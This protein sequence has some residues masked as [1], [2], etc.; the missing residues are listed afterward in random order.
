MKDDLIR[1]VLIVYLALLVPIDWVVMRYSGFNVDGDAIS[2]MDLADLM[3]HGHWASVANGYWNPLY[4]AL[5]A[6]AQK[7]AHP[8]RWNELG[9]YLV[10]NYFIFAGAVAAMW[11]FVSSLDRLRAKMM[12]AGA[13]PLLGLATLR[14]LGIALLVVASQRE[15]GLDKVRSDTLLQALMMMAFAMLMESLA[16]ASLWW[17]PLMGVFFGLAYL[18]K[19]FAFVVALLTIALMVV[20]QAWLQ[21]RP[22]SRVVLAGTLA[23]VAFVAVAGP[24][25]ASLSR[26]K[27]RLDFGDSGSLNYAW[28]SGGTEKFH[29]QPNQ[30]QRY[31]GAEVHLI[32]PELQLLQHP[33]I[34]SY[35]G[36]PNGTF[37]DWFDASYFNERIKPHL[38][39]GI[40]FRRIRRNIV[41]VAR[42]LLNHPEAWVL[43]AVLLVFGA[44]MRFGNW[45]RNGFWLPMVLLGVAMWG[46][47]G[48]VNIEERYVTL[49]YFVL[50]LPLFA[51]LRAPREQ[52]SWLPRLASA[53]VVLLAFLALG[54]S[55]RTA[56]EARRQGSLAGPG[57]SWRSPLIYGAAAGLGQ[58]GVKPGDEIACMGSGACVNDPYWA[59]IAGVRVLT[60]VYSSG[61]DDLLA[62]WEGLA[63]RAQVESVL[64]SQGAKVLVA[65]FD[66]GEMTHTTPGSAGWVRLG[67]SDFYA[68]P[69]DLPAP[70]VRP[71]AAE[72]W[73]DTDPGP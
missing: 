53:L 58:I 22:L 44:R 4:P 66:P 71:T 32:H 33:G 14:L 27:G 29:L 47:Y 50:I 7:L 59:R 54:E 45:R 28:M 35:K 55:L 41:L 70:P 57:K 62:Q 34:Y 36:E 72:P 6:I 49:A 68:L 26:Q 25:V 12:P 17:A 40:L 61:G 67:R 1:R 8:T 5:L 39:P 60:E 11:V 52:E 19:S 9:V 63:N 64:K 2:F 21:R 10:V 20:F 38:N 16:S 46:I 69:I 3:S 43:L 65:R 48:I 56:A 15:L 23:L 42:Y 18:T 51:V 13:Q 37:P 30:P 31:A 24:F 73:V